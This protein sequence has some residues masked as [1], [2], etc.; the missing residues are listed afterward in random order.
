MTTPV[1]DPP[2]AGREEYSRTAFGLALAIDARI[3]LPGLGRSPH[4]AADDPP[5]HVRLDPDELNRRWEALTTTPLRAREL[6]FGETVLLTVDFAEPA[7]YLMWADGFGR[8]LI[9]PDGT[10]LLCEPEPGSNGWANILPFQALPLAATIRGLEVMHASGVV[11]DDGAVLVAGPPGAGKSSLAAALVR[12]G[13][14]L[15]SDDAVALQLRDGAL[16]AHAGST[17]LQ[18]R[19]SEGERLSADDRAALGRHAGTV[20]EKQRYANDSTPDPAPLAGLFLLAHSDEQPAVEQLAAVDPFELI[21]STFN[22]SVRSPARLQRQL[23]VVSAIAADK[24]AH[25][26]RVQPGVNATELAAMIQAHLA[27]VVA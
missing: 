9:S 11:L 15:L 16:I 18:L 24:L 8:I 27:V 20:G 3:S 13:G 10:E 19:A 6:R 17:V 21:A 25:R 1:E 14:Q 23:E 22:L 12:A 26:L 5:S 2:R 4:T 7:G